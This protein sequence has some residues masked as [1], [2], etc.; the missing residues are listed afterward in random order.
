MCHTELAQVSDPSEPLAPWF[1][2][3]SEV[4]LGLKLMPKESGVSLCSG[5]TMRCSKAF[6]AFG[7]ASGHLQ[8]AKLCAATAL[9]FVGSQLDVLMLSVSIRSKETLVGS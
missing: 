1:Y 5:R 4:V 8:W 6:A 3:F 2:P 9:L 7:K